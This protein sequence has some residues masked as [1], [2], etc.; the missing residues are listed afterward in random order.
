MELEIDATPVRATLALSNLL[1]ISRVPLSQSSSR[2]T[3]TGLSA[4]ER[5]DLGIREP[6]SDRWR[7]N[8]MS[9]NRREAASRMFR[10]MRAVTTK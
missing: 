3:V 4:K 8:E 7:T 5:R 6:I 1:L 10:M 9:S 2:W